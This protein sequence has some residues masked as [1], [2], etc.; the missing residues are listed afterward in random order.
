[1][2]HCLFIFTAWNNYWAL[3]FS[4]LRHTTSRSPTTLSYFNTHWL[5]GV[6]GWAASSDLHCSMTGTN[7]RLPYNRSE[8]S[9]GGPRCLN[10][11]LWFKGPLSPADTLDEPGCDDDVL[12]KIFLQFAKPHNHD[13]NR[14]TSYSIRLKGHSINEKCQHHFS[15]PGEYYTACDLFGV[16]YGFG[17]HHKG[18]PEKITRETSCEWS[19]FGFG[20]WHFLA[21]FEGL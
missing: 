13:I 7:F 14:C 9:A 16:L 15:N 11:P 10:R 21:M 17:R 19:Q 20:E 6:L 12:A 8:A 1:M 3:I 18:F 4:V 2:L 5:V